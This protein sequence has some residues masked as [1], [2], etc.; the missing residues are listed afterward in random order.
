MPLR[1]PQ[2]AREAEEEHKEARQLIGRIRNTTEA[3]HLE[4]LMTEPEQAI[5]HHI[6][7]EEH[8]MLPKARQ[9]LSAEER[10]EMGRG[11]EA[12]KQSTGRQS[13]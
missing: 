12:A 9:E 7:E 4:E 8:E 13:A 6:S 5:Q 3:T 11:F 10:N 2:L 1:A